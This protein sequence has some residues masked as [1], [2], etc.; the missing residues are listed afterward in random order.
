MESSESRL[1]SDAY[2]AVAFYLMPRHHDAQHAT[3]CGRCAAERPDEGWLISD[4]DNAYRGSRPTSRVLRCET[5]PATKDQVARA[6][7]LTE[8]TIGEH[9]MCDEAV[10]LVSELATNVVLHS[11]AELFTLVI[12]ETTGGDLKI[13]VIDDGRADTT[14]YLRAGQPADSVNGRGMRLVDQLARQWGFTRERPSGLAVW[15]TLQGR[16]RPPVHPRASTSDRQASDPAVGRRLF[17]RW[18]AKIINYG[19]GGGAC[20]V[21]ARCRVLLPI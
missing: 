1:A 18:L 5:Y 13:A 7:R 19:S 2:I 9:P 8:Q 10:L 3:G 6:R 12:S 21:T 20:P 17:L 15:F 11:G 16:P 4:Y 14:P